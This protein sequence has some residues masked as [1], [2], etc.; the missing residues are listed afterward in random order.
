MTALT[1]PTPRGSLPW[2]EDLL[3]DFPA[4]HIPRYDGRGA[5]RLGTLESAYQVMSYATLAARLRNETF[6]YYDTLRT[7]QRD[8]IGPG[9]ETVAFAKAD[10][11]MAERQLAVLLPVMAELFEEHHLTTA[12]RPEWM[13]RLDL[14]WDYIIEYVYTADTV[15]EVFVDFLRPADWKIY[16][17]ERMVLVEEELDE[18][19]SEGSE[20]MG[21]LPAVPLVIIAVVGIVTVGVIITRGMDDV[22][23]YLF[24]ERQMLF[25]HVECAQEHLEEWVSTGNERALEAY[26]A[27]HEQAEVWAAEADRVNWWSVL[28]WGGA[29]YVAYQVYKSERSRT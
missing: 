14:G 4:D 3:E 18:L 26:R 12:D 6:E 7:M 15:R 27:C 11:L 23:K 5:V 22:L 24:Y 16:A 29:A 10:W 8:G 1:L 9:A 25:E 2:D 19:R 28:L 21:A 17:E 13:A 20:E